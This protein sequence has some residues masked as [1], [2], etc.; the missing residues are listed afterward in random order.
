MEELSNWLEHGKG[1][2]HMN[3]HKQRHRKLTFVE[4]E[5]DVNDTDRQKLERGYDGDSL[6]YEVPKKGGD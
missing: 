3:L 5:G 4:I 2:S 6:L 1:I